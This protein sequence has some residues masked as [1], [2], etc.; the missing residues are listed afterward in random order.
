MQ[1]SLTISLWIVSKVLIDWLCEA[2]SLWIICCAFLVP[3]TMLLASGISP[4]MN[5]RFGCLWV[6]SGTHDD[7]FIQKMSCEMGCVITTCL[8]L[9]LFCE[10]IGG[11][12]DVMTP[13]MVHLYI[14]VPTKLRPHFWKGPIGSTC[15][16]DIK[17]LVV[18]WFNFGTYCTF[19]R[20]GFLWTIGHH[21][22]LWQSFLPVPSST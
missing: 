7:T 2:I 20:S 9:N 10:V 17:A 5:V 8:D 16:C 19:C 13:G 18:C 1:F 6:W 22:L 21:K 11:N 3:H 14:N 15:R 4:L 12:E